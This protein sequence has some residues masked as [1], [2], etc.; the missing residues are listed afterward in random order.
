[1]SILM[2][3]HQAALAAYA[4]G[5]DAPAVKGFDELRVPLSVYLLPC[6]RSRI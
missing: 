5:R 2:L 4:R 6:A 1:M 3:S